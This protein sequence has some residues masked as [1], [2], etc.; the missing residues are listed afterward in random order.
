MGKIANLPGG[1]GTVGIT[2]I[3]GLSFLYR[4][5]YNYTTRRSNYFTK[6]FFN[7]KKEYSTMLHLAGL[8]YVLRIPVVRIGWRNSLMAGYSWSRAD[9]VDRETNF[10]ES[11]VMNGVP[12]P[13]RFMNVWKIRN[14][15][16]RGVA[17]AFWSGFQFNIAPFMAPFID[18]GLFRSFYYRDLG[19]KMILGFHMMAGIRFIFGGD[20]G[21]ND[22]R[23]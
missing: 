11:G 15:R 7:D 2:I 22:G 19:G 1:G 13:V 12:G 10:L 3:D 6:Y 18:F 4:G 23:M 16:D 8:E 9:V 21:E 5:M 14:L 17:V 20:G